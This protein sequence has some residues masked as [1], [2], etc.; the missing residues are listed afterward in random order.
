LMFHQPQG[1]AAGESCS[2][3]EA[4]VA[5]SKG[6][7][8]T[9][10]REYPVGVRAYGVTPAPAAP[11]VTSESASRPLGAAAR[12]ADVESRM[13]TTETEAASVMRAAD[14][15]GTGASD[16]I[17]DAEA[18]PIVTPAD[19][20]HSTQQQQQQQQQDGGSTTVCTAPLTTTPVLRETASTATASQQQMLET[21]AVSALGAL[22]VAGD[23]P[24]TAAAASAA[25]WS[26]QRE[27]APAP[28]AEPMATD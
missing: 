24:A 12:V 4:A 20:A 22:A 7:A 26:G 2:V 27:E 18:E 16:A 5:A 1:D 19:D 9:E 21:R 8:P 17:A 23:A 3:G 6:V 10:C 11:H 28:P 15:G 25:A 14:A 13:D